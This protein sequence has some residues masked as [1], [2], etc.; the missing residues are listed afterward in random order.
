MKWVF[1][2]NGCMWDYIEIRNDVPAGMPG[3]WHVDVFYNDTY[4]FTEDFTIEEGSC[5]VRQIYGDYS[6]K[7]QFLR[8]VRDNVLNTTQE[9]REIIKLYY[10]WS[11]VIVQ[12]MDADDAFK[13]DVRELIEGALLLITEGKPDD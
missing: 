11:P 2:G 4:Q 7:T 5:A 13:R 1:T 3:D 8:Y 12:A 9:G 10:Q 6:T